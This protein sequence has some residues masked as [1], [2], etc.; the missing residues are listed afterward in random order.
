MAAFV[1]PDHSI[2]GHAAPKCLV[3]DSHTSVKLFLGKIFR[4]VV[5]LP[6]DLLLLF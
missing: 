2:A 3:L 6:I 5:I 1:Y 4:E